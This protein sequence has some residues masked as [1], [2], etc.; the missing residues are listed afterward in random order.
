M[1]DHSPSVVMV[2]SLIKYVN[3]LFFIFVCEI[4]FVQIIM[5]KIVLASYAVVCNLYFP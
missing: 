5:I 1:D 4:R 3:E 2:L